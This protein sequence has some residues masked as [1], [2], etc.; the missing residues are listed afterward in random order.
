V[1][2]TGV[3][4]RYFRQLA[5]ISMPG[6]R[7]DLADPVD[8]LGDPER[9]RRLLA[10]P[11]RNACLRATIAVTGLSAGRLAN[12]ISSDAQAIIDCRLLPGDDR[13]AF[14]EALVSVVDDEHCRFEI[15]ASS[16]ASES[17]ADTDL[18]HA[19]LRARDRF[20]PGVPVLTPPLTSSTD[21][22]RL[23]GM[24]MIVYGFEPFHLSYEDE[25]SHGDDERLSVE[26]LGFGIEVTLEI[27]SDV[28]GSGAANGGPS[29]GGEST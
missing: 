19:I 8:A 16:Q 4:D 28:A 11:F 15:L 7:D 25:H 5:G 9:A 6:L 23:R 13:E 21:A 12:I 29:T 14:L 26:N 10:D 27:V 20:E 24:G 2:L 3:V 22:G 1:R 18:F 17:P